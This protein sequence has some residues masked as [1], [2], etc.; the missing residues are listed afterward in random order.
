MILFLSI[1]SATPLPIEHSIRTVTDCL[2]GH[3]ASLT[4]I[5]RRIHRRPV[6]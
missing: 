4:A 3:G 6:H 1:E 2:P 5:E